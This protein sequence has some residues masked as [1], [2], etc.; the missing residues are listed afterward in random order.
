[1]AG[2]IPYHDT[3]SRL[4]PPFV[5]VASTMIV[6]FVTISFLFTVSITVLFFTVFLV[7]LLGIFPIVLLA[8][9]H[10]QTSCRKAGTEN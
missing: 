8:G 7:E 1:M 6:P 9:N 5:M 4:V 10:S 3:P 2:Y